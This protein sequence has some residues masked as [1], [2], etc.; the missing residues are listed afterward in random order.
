MS[1]IRLI[2]LRASGALAL[3]AREH[4][5]QAAQVAALRQQVDT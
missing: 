1:E 5:Q 3:Y 4:T 2:K